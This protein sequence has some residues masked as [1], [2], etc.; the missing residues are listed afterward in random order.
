MVW[1]GKMRRALFCCLRG[2]NC[3]IDVHTRKKCNFCRF[4]KC[5][6]KGMVT[7]FKEENINTEIPTDNTKDDEISNIR[8][9][10]ATHESSTTVCFQFGQKET[11]NLQFYVDLFRV[12]K[13]VKPVGLPNI[14][15][16]VECCRDRV[17]FPHQLVKAQTKIHEHWWSQ[18]C[19]GLEEFQDLN[20]EEKRIVLQNTPLAD[21]LTQGLYLGPGNGTNLLSICKGLVSDKTEMEVVHNYLTKKDLS[22]MSRETIKYE[23]WRSSPWNKSAEFEK[24]HLLLNKEIVTWGQKGLDDVSEL[25]VCL[26][27]LFSQE[28]GGQ[29]SKKIGHFHDKW[30]F[31]LWSYLMGQNLMEETKNEL[32]KGALS[33]CGITKQIW[34]IEQNCI[35]C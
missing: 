13:E 35:N 30:R 11:G 26:L 8:D 24:N 22:I 29:F 19:N 4:E 27:I 9:L 34:K 31:V 23:H 6:L 21:R 3:T 1:K 2:G 18:F 25:L 15:S 17:S 14:I 5:K 7:D 28:V 16:M 33:M 20:P 10:V 32:Y 12:Q